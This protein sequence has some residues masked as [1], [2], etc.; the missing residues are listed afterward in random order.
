M[1]L[2]RSRFLTVLPTKA[3]SAYF[4]VAYPNHGHHLLLVLEP[5]VMSDSD[6]VSGPQTVMYLPGA[7]VCYSLG[8]HH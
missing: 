1:S 3:L 8:Y 2:S 4:K 7:P 6:R 5:H